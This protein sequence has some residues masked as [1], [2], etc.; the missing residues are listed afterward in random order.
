MRNG[1]D[2]VLVAGLIAGAVCGIAGTLVSQDS[3]RQLL[4]GID[5]VGVIL[6]T[7]LLAVRFLRTG[8]DTVAAGFL[9]FALGESLL[10]SGT[11]AGLDGSVPSFGGGVALWAAGLLLISIPKTL[12]TWVRGAGIVAALLFT[13]VSARIF[14][15]EHLVPTSSPLPFFA[16]PFVVLTFVGWIVT[17]LKRG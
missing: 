11:A 16:Y 1:S 8:N 5:G 6:A 7:A 14:L 4:W 12:A 13:V 3:L 10:V 9:V 15:G 17:V 2:L